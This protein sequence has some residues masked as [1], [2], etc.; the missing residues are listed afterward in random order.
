[1]QPIRRDIHFDLDPKKVCNWRKGD[2]K[3]THFYNALSIFFPEGERFFIHAVRHFRSQITDPELREAVTAFIGQEAMHGREHT[4]YNNAMTQAGL[5]AD[6]L[7]GVVVSLLE[8]IKRRTPAQLQ[9]S[10]TIALEHLTAILADALLTHPDWI[11]RSDSHYRSL[12]RWHALEETEHKAVAFD[13]YDRIFGRGFRA[14]AVRCAGHLGA[15]AIFWPM[16]LAFHIR[17]IAADRDAPRLRGW[18]E[19]LNILWNPR[20]GFFPSIVRPWLSYFRRDFHPWDHDNRELLAR[21]DEFLGPEID[22]EP[23]ALAA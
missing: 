18:G 6:R 23:A 5:P 15:N 12:W 8:D 21:M 14:Y 9:L 7:E 4:D 16:V 2:R 1:M 13:V 11:E 22:A 3:V 19:T 17:L 20:S 10:V